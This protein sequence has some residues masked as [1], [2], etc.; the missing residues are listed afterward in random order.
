M[1]C[2]MVEYVTSRAMLYPAHAVCYGNYSN[3]LPCLIWHSCTSPWSCQPVRRVNLW[4]WY[5]KLK[6]LCFYEMLGT[7]HPVTV[8]YPRRHESSTNC[9][10]RMYARCCLA[11]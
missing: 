6:T 2:C 3:T 5:F 11:L 1:L 8:T 7:I 10:C 9:I 4:P